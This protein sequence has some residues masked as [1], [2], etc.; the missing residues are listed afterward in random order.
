MTHSLASEKLNAA[1]RQRQCRHY[2]CRQHFPLTATKLYDV[3]P[4]R[5]YGA[6]SFILKMS[7]SDSKRTLD[8]L[9]HAMNVMNVMHALYALYAL[10]ALYAICFSRK[11]TKAEFVDKRATHEICGKVRH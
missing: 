8:K 11:K 2:V 5:K 6:D 3:L 9:K 1:T 10:H 4:K 7:Q